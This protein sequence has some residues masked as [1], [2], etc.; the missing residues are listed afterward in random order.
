MAKVLMKLLREF[1][2]ALHT[3]FT[4]ARLARQEI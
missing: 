2:Q 3:V 4:S 1:Q